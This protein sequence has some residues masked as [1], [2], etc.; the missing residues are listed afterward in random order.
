[1]QKLSTLLLVVAAFTAIEASSSETAPIRQFERNFHA[2][3]DPSSAP[4]QPLLSDTS[5]LFSFG[6]LEVNGSQIDLAVVHLPSGKPVWRAA[7]AT[8]QPALW[9]SGATLSFNGSLVLSDSKAG[10]LWSSSG[11]TSGDR[12]ILLNSSNLQI[13]KLAETTSV[14]WQ[15]FDF[16]SDTIVQAQNFTSTAAL[17]SDGRRYSMRLG[18]KYLALFMEFGQGVESPMYWKR[19]AMEIKSQIVAGDGPIYVRID[20]T[21]FLGFYQKEGSLI[22]VVSFD[23]FNRGI[24]GFRR[25]TLEDD[26]DLRGYFWNGTI[27]VK[28]FVAID[29]FCGLP[30][31][32]GSYGLCNEDE[33]KCGC[34]DGRKDGCFSPYSGELCLGKDGF[35]PLRR[36][37]VELPNK[38]WLESVKMEAWGH[39]EES[40]ERNC[41]CR[42]AFYNNATGYCY[43][44][45]YPVQTVVAVGDENEMGYFKVSNSEI[46]GGGGVGNRRRKMVALVV[47]G[48]VVAAAG[49][50]VGAWGLRRVRRRARGDRFTA[51][52]LPSGPYKDLNSASFRSVELA[53][54]FRK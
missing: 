20:P 46:D 36:N 44:M 26:G 51:E 38:E 53:G 3:S 23:S 7:P 27:W 28:D 47:V 45:N 35:W 5:G 16:P 13:V 21:G 41:S 10:V 37:G 15:S 2:I 14:L 9:S 19:T 11:V 49:I 22:D 43:R 24:T 1:M 33:Q 39:C 52:G 29:Q 6:F 4:F 25:V 54:S 30:R 40:C 17:F 12:V 31:A 50:V 32:C 48:V 18:D 8:A 34:I 42:G